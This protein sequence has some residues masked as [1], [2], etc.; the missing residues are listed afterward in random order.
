[1]NEETHTDVRKLLKTFGVKAD[2]AIT[3]YLERFPGGEP[4]TFR[5]T[6]ES[7]DGP[8]VPLQVEI[9]QKVRRERS[10]PGLE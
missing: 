5:I 8:D 9:E 4:V 7:I 6:L 10:M 1:M 3:E 2:E